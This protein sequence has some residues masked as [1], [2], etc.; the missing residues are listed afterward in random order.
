MEELLE[1]NNE[2]A[3]VIVAAW[4]I[5]TK[6]LEG[7]KKKINTSLN[8][9]VDDIMKMTLQLLRNIGDIMSHKPSEKAE[10]IVMVLS[11]M[12]SVILYK[13]FHDMLEKQFWTKKKINEVTSVRHLVGSE[14]DFKKKKPGPSWAWLVALGNHQ[15]PGID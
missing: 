15:I 3:I 1:M 7:E 14:W 10:I 8:L 6:R 12:V 9:V 2:G 11:K 5:E 4:R 13:K